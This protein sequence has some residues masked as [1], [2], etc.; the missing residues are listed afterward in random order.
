[1]AWQGYRAYLERRG[2][3]AMERADL[4]SREGIR[5]QMLTFASNGELG[6]VSNAFDNLL[7][8]NIQ[9]LTRSSTHT[10]NHYDHP[11]PDPMSH[12]M[13]PV[14]CPMS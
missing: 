1:M 9:P 8:F 13:S 10:H 5:R 3:L 2:G 4:A 11:N 12:P 7:G 6:P 14:L